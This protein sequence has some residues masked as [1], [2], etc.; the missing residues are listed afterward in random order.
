[1]KAGQENACAVWS[2]FDFPFL[3]VSIQDDGLGKAKGFEA[4]IQR[5]MASS[6]SEML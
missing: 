2:L 6:V 5:M 3:R 4:I 1:M